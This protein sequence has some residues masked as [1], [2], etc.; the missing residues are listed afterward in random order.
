MEDFERTLID[1][2]LGDTPDP[3]LLE[4]GEYEMKIVQ[5]SS[6]KSKDSIRDLI[7]VQLDCPSEPMAESLFVYL[8]L[9]TEDD[10]TK[11]AIF[12]KRQLKDFFLCFGIDM[13]SPGEP[14]EWRGYVGQVNIGVQISDYTGEQENYVRKFLH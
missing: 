5:A 14:P 6:G 8:G 1:L 10:P 11:T 12:L 13:K 2:N 7:K 4:P 9:P 3:E